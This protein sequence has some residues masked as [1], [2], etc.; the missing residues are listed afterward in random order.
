MSESI[1]RQVVDTIVRLESIES[2]QGEVDRLWREIKGLFLNE[3][4]SLPSIP[5]TNNKKLKKKVSERLNH[6]GTLN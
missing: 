5:M 2:T 3:M 4:E 6:F 1:T